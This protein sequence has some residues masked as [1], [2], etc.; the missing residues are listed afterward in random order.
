MT[1]G[2]FLETMC[3]ILEGFLYIYLGASVWESL[4]KKPNSSD[5]GDEY[6][7]F[8]LT[9][10]GIQMLL[11]IVCRFI[12]VILVAL[13]FRR[14]KGKEKWRLNRYHIMIISMAQIY[15][16]CV[17][18]AQIQCIESENIK[19]DDIMKGSITIMMFFTNIIF[20]AAFPFFVK[21]NLKQIANCP[22]YGPDH[23]SILDPIMD[24]ENENA[25]KNIASGG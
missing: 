11:S 15:R 25:V 8:S 10:T 21:W 23:P 17:A 1:S 4:G 12:S 7:A 6:S 16:G 19:A 20:G 3:L 13:M 18:F 14:I 5:S 22:R 9:F 24:K 2:I